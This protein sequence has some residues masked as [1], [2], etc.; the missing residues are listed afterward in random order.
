MIG[1]TFH[2]DGNTNERFYISRRR[3]TPMKGVSFQLNE[4]LRKVL[5]FT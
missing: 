1:F 2:I 3:E 4:K 5:Q